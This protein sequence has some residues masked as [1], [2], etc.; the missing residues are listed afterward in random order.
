MTCKGR[1]AFAGTLLVA[2]QLCLGSTSVHA[3]SCRELA[4]Q[5]AQALT[6]PDV[7]AKRLDANKRDRWS[8]QTAL[9]CVAADTQ[10]SDADKVLIARVLTRND[11]DFNLI[12]NSGDSALHHSVAAGA[13][14]LATYLMAQGADPDLAN[15]QGESPFQM[16][17]KSTNKALVAVF[18]SHGRFVDNKNASGETALYEAARRGDLELVGQLI[19]RGANAGTSNRNALVGAALGGHADVARFLIEQI[20][21]PVDVRSKDGETPLMGAAAANQMALAQLLVETFGADSSLV[22]P[23]GYSALSFA[24]RSGHVEMVRYLLDRG[25]SIETSQPS[26]LAAAALAR[27]PKVV[28]LLLERGAHLD[29]GTVEKPGVL[30]WAAVGG[31]E[32]VLTALIDHGAAFPALPA[33]TGLLIP[34]ILNGHYGRGMLA[35]GNRDGATPYLR[36]AI[37]NYRGV[38]ADLAGR[39]QAMGRAANRLQTKA[40][41]VN[42]F[43]VVFGAFASDYQAR[44]SAATYAQIESLNYAL[45]SG[46]GAN[47][48]FDAYAVLQPTAQGSA[49]ASNLAF[50]KGVDVSATHAESIQSLLADAS[51]LDKLAAEYRREAD[52]IDDLLTCP[53]PAAPGVSSTESCAAG[54]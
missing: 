40:A 53:P 31:D 2:A 54:R 19:D 43:I 5:L 41:I 3:A 24:A 9:M 29:A 47:G 33:D 22:S 16:A 42:S 34:A 14:D 21:I 10:F 49:A 38:A 25:A 28:N 46:T 12:D 36:Q 6:K 35:R 1:Q 18:A 26:A 7:V 23:V 4:P 39:S 17:M 30:Y 52:Q 50:I 20:H 15:L 11:T 13:A 27:Q 45:R 32:S 37:T 48:Y 44:H 51:T 8:G